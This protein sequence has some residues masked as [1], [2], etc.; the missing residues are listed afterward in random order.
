MTK[1]ELIA[2]IAQQTGVE[3]T[4]VA[5]VVETYMATVKECVAKGKDNVY[6]RGFGTF[7]LKHRA[8]KTGRNI[9]KNTTID[10]PA[11]DI[12]YF[13]PAKEFTAAVKE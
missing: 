1:A 10:I 3:K 5:A 4:A 12:P 8:A 2:E 9:T 7:T 6:L 13:K 11:R